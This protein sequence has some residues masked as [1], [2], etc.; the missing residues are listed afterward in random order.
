MTTTLWIAILLTGCQRNDNQAT[1]KQPIKVK[2][3]TVSASTDGQGKSYSGTVEEGN[4]TYLSFPVMGTVK[5][6]HFHLGQHISKVHLI[7]PL[8]KAVIMPINHH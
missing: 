8:C 2:V 5:T 1:E 4:G 7:R 6:L 3:I